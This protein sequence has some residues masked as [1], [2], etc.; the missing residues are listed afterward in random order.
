MT[1]APPATKRRS[2][3]FSG[4]RPAASTSKLPDVPM[5]IT[6]I[7]SP[8][9]GMARRA[10]P[11]AAWWVEAKPGRGCR[12]AAAAVSAAADRKERRLVMAAPRVRT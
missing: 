11:G 3:S 10:M 1:L 8:E 9:D 5:P 12:A 2:T 6:G 7:V 4:S